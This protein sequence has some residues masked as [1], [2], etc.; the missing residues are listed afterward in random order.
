M[1]DSKCKV[2]GGSFLI[3]F[4]LQ[5]A[6]ELPLSTLDFKCFKIY[7]MIH[8]YRMGLYVD[9]EYLNTCLQWNSYNFTSLF[10]VQSKTCSYLTYT[11]SVSEAGS[12]ISAS[13]YCFQTTCMYQKVT[14][15]QI[16][17]AHPPSYAKLFTYKLSRYLKVS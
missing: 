10:S 15:Y 13:N 17:T 1:K 2:R 4:H 12:I 5:L 16:T 7:E 9:V 8:V 14:N 11:G 3:H 6:S